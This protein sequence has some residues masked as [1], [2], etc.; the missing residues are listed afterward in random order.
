[1][2]KKYK[3]IIWKWKWFIGHYT[4]LSPNKLLIEDKFLGPIQFLADSVA[5]SN[6]ADFLAEPRFARAYQKAHET[7]PW[8]GFEMQWR[9]FI[10]CSLAE[11]VKKLPGDFVEC[12]VNTGAYS[13]AIIDYID[14]DRTGKTFYLFD[15]YE[16][17]VE[18]QITVEERAQGIAEYLGTYRNV[19]EQVVNTFSPF[20]AKIIKG[21]VPDTLDQCQSG[22]ICYLSI[23]MN[24]VAP[25]IAAM[26]YFW[27]KVVTGG[28]IVLDDYG[29]PGHINQ[30]LAFDA[31]AKAKGVTIIYIPTGQGIIFKN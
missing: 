15:T 5:T 9:T 29:F 20:N 30:K 13:R 16:G 25:E 24:V 21:M 19:Y 12:G 11:M 26:H 18:G 6:N 27:D 2:V 22:Q 23:D 17:L 28:V 31:F 14:F 8:K 7:N 10:V 3:T 4:S 1:M